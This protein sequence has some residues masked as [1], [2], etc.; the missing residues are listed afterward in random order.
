MK[1]LY[2]TLLENEVS[3]RYVNQMMDEGEKVLQNGSSVD[4][5]LSNVYQKLEPKAGTAGS[6]RDGG[7]EAESDL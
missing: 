7:Q 3:E 2:R 1:M 6:H 5:I 4:V